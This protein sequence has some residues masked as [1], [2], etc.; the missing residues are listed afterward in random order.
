MSDEHFPTEADPLVPRSGSD[1]RRWRDCAA[2][3][4]E[5]GATW[6]WD[7]CYVHAVHAERDRLTVPA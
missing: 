1:Y 7:R 4:C 6:P 3:G 5:V 2:D